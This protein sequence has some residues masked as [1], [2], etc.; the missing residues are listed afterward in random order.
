MKLNK[1]YRS[2]KR[3]RYKLFFEWLYIKVERIRKKVRK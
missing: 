3:K 1:V 2:R